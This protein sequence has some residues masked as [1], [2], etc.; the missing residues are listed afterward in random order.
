[1]RSSD[2]GTGIQLPVLSSSQARARLAGL[3]AVTGI[4]INRSAVFRNFVPSGLKSYNPD[5]SSGRVELLSFTLIFTVPDT[6]PAGSCSSTSPPLSSK[7]AAAAGVTSCSRE[8]ILA[9]SCCLSAA[10]SAAV[11]AVPETAVVCPTRPSGSVLSAVISTPL[12]VVPVLPEPL[13]LPP[14]SPFLTV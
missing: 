4:L 14:K 5:T 3:A 2:A 13:T 10:A 6:A 7:E 11:M 1:M 12:T 9:A 8:T